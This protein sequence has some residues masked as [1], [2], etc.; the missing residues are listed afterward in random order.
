M[1]LLTDDQLIDRIYEA[2]IVPE[3]WPLALDQ[4]AYRV[5]A[6]GTFLFLLSDG[7]NTSWTC[8]EAL[9]EV[10][11][12]W[13]E[14]GWQAKTR[15]AP[16]MMAM[17]HA[18]FITESDAYAPG[19]VEQDEAIMNYLR[20]AGFGWA[21]GTGIAMPTGELAVYNVERR[22]ETGPMNRADCLKLDPLRPHLAR[23]ALLST[24]AGLERARAMA[25]TLEILGVAGAVV[26]P[27][28]RLLATNPMF[29]H[30]MPWVFQD[31]RDR[32][33]LTDAS[34]DGLLADAMSGLQ[35]GVFKG[36]SS[37]PVRA[38]ESRPPLIVHL[39][40]VRGAAHD[41]FL[42]AS[43]VIM[44]TPVD[45]GTVPNVEV[46]QGLFD[47]SPAESRVAQGIAA[48]Q[49]IDTLA[50]RIGVA[51]ETVRTQLKAVLAKTGVGRQAE[52]VSLLAG[53]MP[54]NSDRYFSEGS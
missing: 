18:G 22:S 35:S 16:K 38:A 51:R 42:N 8:S 39:L 37:I 12:G 49:T 45:R 27:G 29:E 43:L 9:K 10:V 15:R 11:T 26:R 28:G 2:S 53:T 25:T 13:V 31:R 30:L 44:V 46:L 36:V 40:P 54:P 4:L 21:A 7:G 17:N 3:L 52:L 5:D 23:A 20:P 1:K 41:F 24:R 19:E 48:A 6:A 14:G 50:A 33:G 34:A 32:L 47:L